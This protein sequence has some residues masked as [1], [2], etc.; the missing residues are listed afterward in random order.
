ML[1]VVLDTHV[2]EVFE[3]EWL[4]DILTH[5]LGGVVVFTL[6]DDMSTNGTKP[7]AH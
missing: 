4:L 5:T 7:G 1:A 3:C 6:Q 2:H